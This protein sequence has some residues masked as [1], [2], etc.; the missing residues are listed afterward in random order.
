VHSLYRGDA[1]HLEKGMIE[2]IDLM[3]FDIQDLGLRFYTYIATLKN[4]MEDC[5]EFGL[6][7]VVLDRPNPLGGEEVEGNILGADSLSFVGPIPCPYATGSPSASWQ[8]LRSQCGIN[9]DL[10]VVPMSG[11]RRGNLFDDLGRNW[12]MTSPAL[13]H[14]SGALLYAGMC[15]FEGT[16]LSEGGNLLSLRVDRSPLHRR[17]KPLRRSEHPSAPG[18]QI[19]PC[20]FYPGRGQTR[21]KP[22]L[23][24]IR[25]CDG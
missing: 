9:C 14:F 19:Y 24:D 18:D 10:S 21:G 2:G 7:L 20:L 11:W 17:G 6:P 22:L 23:R 3:V 25:P 4:L 16:N 1:R 13:G 15:L 8:A 12:M 5:A